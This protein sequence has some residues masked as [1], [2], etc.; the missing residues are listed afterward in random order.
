MN[1]VRLLFPFCA[2]EREPCDFGRMALHLGGHSSSPG[3]L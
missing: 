3:S 2:W 1:E